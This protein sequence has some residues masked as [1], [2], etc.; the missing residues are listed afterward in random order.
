MDANVP[1]TLT[2]GDT[3][4]W[5][6]DIPDYPAPTWT[7]SYLFRNQSDGSDPF[8]ASA[9][10]TSFAITVAAATTATIKPGTYRWYAQVLSAGVRKTVEQGEVEV[11][12]NPANA[13][14]LDY[15][16]PSRIMLDALEA[17]LIGRASR[18]QLAMSL[19]GRSIS[20]TP[21]PELVQW[22]DTLR[23]EVLSEGAAETKGRGRD[24][25]LRILRG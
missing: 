5:T 22:R 6:R 20:R 10:G 13:G 1:A 14:A 15:R 18:D 24:I 19:N 8:A 17:T 2:A 7:L 25:K 4:Q 23:T 21:L 16:S 12:Q 9:S 3:W 11:L